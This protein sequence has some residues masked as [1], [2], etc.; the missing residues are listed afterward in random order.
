MSYSLIIAETRKGEFQ[1][2]NFDPLYLSDIVGLPSY[3]LLPEGEYGILRGSC[4]KVIVAPLKE[5]EFLNPLNIIRLLERT[6]Q[7]FGEPSA[8]L[9]P[10][11]SFGIDVAPYVA[12]RLG[13]PIITDISGFC[14]GEEGEIF[15]KTLYSEKINGHFR[16]KE[17]M[18][19]VGTVRKGVFPKVAE[20][21]KETLFEEA[22]S[23][24]KDPRRDFIEYIEEEIEDVDITKADLLVS[25]GRGV[26]EKGNIP[27]FEE[28]AALLG[29][30]LSCSR[31]VADRAWLPKA[32]QVGTSGKT[33]RPKVYF[34]LGISG[35][36]QHIA[37][38]KDS[39]VI[40]AVN[41]DPSAPIFQYAHYGVVED[42]HRLAQK[43]IENLRDQK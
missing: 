32:R 35:A 24:E 6:F 4:D 29:G 22:P 28:L 11:C 3:I 33:V 7:A 41:K 36:F 1:E 27:L 20:V 13:W 19:F 23:I 25:V 8:I 12:G 40:I 5:G 15:I 34:A 21:V 37:G 18:R 2:G 26:K 30:V 43:M 9:L 14:R 31:P 38:M 39:D 17:G 42:M 16:L 10:H